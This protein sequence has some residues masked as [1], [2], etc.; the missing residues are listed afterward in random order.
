MRL[1]WAGKYL[2]EK[3]TLMDYN[4]LGEATIDQV[5]KTNLNYFK[6]KAQNGKIYSLVFNPNN[7]IFDIKS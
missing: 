2:D 6:I 1:V 3:K 5:F 7:T 4:I